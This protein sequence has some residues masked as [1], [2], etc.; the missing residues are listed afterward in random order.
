MRGMARRLEALE[1]YAGDLR[2]AHLS[3]DA[4]SAAWELA[5]Y[6]LAD[7]GEPVPVGLALDRQIAWLDHALHSGATGTLQ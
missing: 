3:D 2:L 7:M 5:L 4:L 6:H 1:V